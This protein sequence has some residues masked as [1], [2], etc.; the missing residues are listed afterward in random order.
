MTQQ[1]RT[2]KSLLASGLS[3]LA[4]VALLIGSTFA[5][6]T[7]NVTSGRNQITAGN[8]DVELYAR[9]TDG[10]YQPVNENEALFDDA[11]LWEPGHTEVVY[12]KV[13]NEGTLALKYQ[14][15]VTVES[16][17][18]GTN[19]DG[20]AFNLSD[21]LVFGQAVGTTET[22]YNTRAAAQAAAGEQMG[23]NDYTKPGN[24]LSGA[25]EY[26]AL[27]VYMPEGVGNKAN[28]KTGTTAPS[29]QL[30]VNLVAAQD[31][32][33]SD[34]FGTDYDVDAVYPDLPSQ[35]TVQIT[36]QVTSD[37]DTV[38]HDED[39]KVT[40]TIPAGAT[41][42]ETVKL[43]ISTQEV[44][45]D[46]VTYDIS[47]VDE[48]DQVVSLNHPVTVELNIGS[49]L[50][51][52]SVKHSGVPMAA[53]DY[54]YN[55]NSGVLTITTSSFSPFEISYEYAPVARVGSI[56]Y[57][58]VSK[59]I[60]AAKD[61]DTVVV[62]DDVTS[63]NIILNLTAK[64]SVTVDLNGKVLTYTG[65]NR[66]VQLAYGADMTILNGTIHMPNLTNS[67]A[68]IF[69]YGGETPDDGCKLTMKQVNVTSSNIG[70]FSQE[71][72]NTIVVEDCNIQ[73]GDSFAVYQNGSTS[74]VDI[75]LKN[76]IISS[77]VTAVYVS[78]SVNNPAKQ[79]LTIENCTIK[80]SSA[81]EIKHTNATITGSTLVGTATPT[82]SGENG[83][84][85]C[86]AG[87]A[88]AVTTNGASDLVTG[89]VQVNDCKF[90]NGDTT[91]GEPNGYCFVYTVA[92]G[93]S[94]TIDGEAVTDYNTYEGN[95]VAG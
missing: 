24:L 31:T 71:P 49:G 20:E 22:I 1:K 3:L 26:I 92:E 47:L 56:G 36:G 75:T 63:E 23:L 91:Q 79:S 11:A 16:E 50:K 2:K 6:F 81:V 65:T 45:T 4:C 12:L 28:Y 9:D 86:T 10:V 61:G 5:W 80:G 66:G 48:Q 19:V 83:N 21:Y 7:D 78:N 60:S 13:A 95:I 62:M 43:V 44:T 76:S 33:E 73:A 85:S 38:L 37:G 51:N 40:A 54:S 67:S 64:K 84:G 69:V 32:V 82:G 8:L 15:A 53:A 29:I 17:T 14:L 30:G 57:T 41:D 39:N 27:V 46:S 94:V 25:E 72:N 35:I 59:A 18:P 68:G 77:E 55:S 74:P 52:V 58:T 89:T 87:Y 34:S 90:Y 88:L 42:E 70:V 93:S